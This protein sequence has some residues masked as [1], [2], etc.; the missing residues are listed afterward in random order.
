MNFNSRDSGK[1]VV[2]R[3]VGKSKDDIRS[4]TRRF[5][6]E[7]RYPENK[8]FYFVGPGYGMSGADAYQIYYNVL[9][10]IEEQVNRGN[11]DEIVMVGWSRGAAI[12]SELTEGLAALSETNSRRDPYQ[13]GRGT[14][15]RNLTN[16]IKSGQL[17]PIKFVGLFDSVSMI[18][19]GSPNDPKWGEDITSQVQYFAH[20]VAGDRTG[21][22]GGLIDF[23]P[24]N[25]AIAAGRQEIMHL[26][27]VNHGG[28]G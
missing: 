14:R 23:Y 3:N 10:T 19:R 28:V 17:P 4:N 6:E 9:R 16:V 11:C 2:G 12:I 22:V 8:K 15:Y 1:D 18:W 5:Y 26:A 13:S 27:H 25:P 7:S 24:A 20:V 21:P